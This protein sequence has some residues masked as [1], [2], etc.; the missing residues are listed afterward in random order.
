MHRGG[1]GSRSRICDSG[2]FLRL[3]HHLPLCCANCCPVTGQQACHAGRFLR[4]LDLYFRQLLACLVRHLEC[5]RV[6]E[7]E[8]MDSKIAI[9][10]RLLLSPSQNPFHPTAPQ[11][12]SISATRKVALRRPA[13]LPHPRLGS[14]SS[15]AMSVTCSPLNKPVCFLLPRAVLLPAS[16]LLGFSASI[17][18][19]AQVG[20]HSQQDATETA[21]PKN[22]QWK[23]LTQAQKNKR[24]HSCPIPTLL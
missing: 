6:E 9:I 17:L 24:H 18:W 3:L 19:V 2:R 10:T 1:A 16:L 23:L 7:L 15:V 20:R 22:G 8:R 13:S 12:H 4:L 11:H 14:L 5:G 21:A